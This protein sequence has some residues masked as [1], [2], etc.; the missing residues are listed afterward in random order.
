MGENVRALQ[1]KGESVFEGICCEEKEQTD[2]LR[3]LKNCSPQIKHQ[4]NQGFRKVL[5]RIRDKD[6]S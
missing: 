6:Q 3:K 1:K 4:I 5:Q 2:S